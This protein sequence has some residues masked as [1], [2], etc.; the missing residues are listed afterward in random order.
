MQR[1]AH[2]PVDA[3][4]GGRLDTFLPAPVQQLVTDTFSAALGLG[5]GGDQPLGE[6][7]GVG[8]AAL[9]EPQCP[10]NL[11]AMELDRAAGPVVERQ[12]GHRHTDLPG[13]VV[14]SG[15]G[16]LAPAAGKPAV[17][18]VKAQQHR[19]PEPRRATLAGHHRQLGLDQRPP[20]DQFV[21]TQLTR[22]ART[23]LPPPGH[24][25][26]QRFRVKPPALVCG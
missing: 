12:L 20:I 8:D 3:A 17:L 23:L 14:H 1:R 25:R 16:D 4:A 21:L 11:A 2:D 26:D 7:V 10:A 18:G 13:H 24:R 6:L 9:P 15:V 19:E 22:H 5:D